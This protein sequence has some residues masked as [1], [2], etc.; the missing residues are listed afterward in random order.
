MIREKV[1]GWT[2]VITA[3]ADGHDFIAYGEQGQLPGGRGFYNRRSDASAEAKRLR[4]EGGFK[5][6][7]E[8]I[9]VA[10]KVGR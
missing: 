5:A 10:L 4:K 2:V 9:S 8:P 7:V 6:R 1:E 3:E